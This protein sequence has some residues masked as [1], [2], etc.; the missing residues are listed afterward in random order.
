MH[1]AT[2]GTL[3]LTGEERAIARSLLAVLDEADRSS[4][5]RAGAG[6]P[7]FRSSELRRRLL[8]DRVFGDPSRLLGRLKRRG[9]LEEGLG[10]P[11]DRVYSVPFPVELREVLIT[12]LQ[13]PEVAE[14]GGFHPVP[15]ERSE[16]RSMDSDFL[17]HLQDLLRN[18]FDATVAFGR[19]F[20]AAKLATYLRDLFGEALYLDILISM[21]QQYA[22]ADVPLLAPTGRS[23]GSTGFHLAGVRLLPCRRDG[24]CWSVGCRQGAEPLPAG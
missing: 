5:R 17:T 18:R 1:V 12:E 4:A 22:L 13:P 6:P 3:E 15:D 14:P 11:T 24:S 21:L 7:R 9:L 8:K 20:S 2:S 19:G 16:I 23:T 10:G